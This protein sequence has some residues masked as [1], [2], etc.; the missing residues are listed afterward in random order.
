[1]KGTGFRKRAEAEI[2]RY[3]KDPWVLIR[4]LG[5]N[6]RDAH[7]DRIDVVTLENEDRETLI[8]SDDGRGMT[9][10][11]ARRYLFRLYASSKDDDEFA[12]G[13]YGVG[14]WSVLL[15]KPDTIE[16]HSRT[17]KGCWAVSLSGDL[18][19]WQSISCR[20]SKPGTTVMLVRKRGEEAEEL[21]RAVEAAMIR[22]LSRLRTAGR[23]P[24]PLPVYFNSRRIVRPFKLDSPASLSFSDVDAEGVVGFGRLPSYQLYARGLPV[25]RGSFLEELEGCQVRGRVDRE[26][27][28]VAPVYL[29]NGNHLDVVLSRQMLISNRSLRRLI[30]TARKRFDQL[31]SLTVGCTVKRTV[32]GKIADSL[33]L[34]DLAPL[35]ARWVMF[36]LFVV[37]ITG[38]LSAV[39][40]KIG[41]AEGEALSA[42][43]QTRML[44]QKQA[45]KPGKD[46][47]SAQPD[48]SIEQG[49]A[50]LK[51]QP[52]LRMMPAI[53]P[54]V[55]KE[56]VASTVAEMERMPEWSL[57]YRPGR[58]L[59]F[60]LFVLDK[61]DPARGWQPDGVDNG[62]TA[63]PYRVDRRGMIRVSMDFEGGPGTLLLPVPSGYFVVG[64]NAWIGE[65]ETRLA[66]NR[67]GLL[68]VVL[69][70]EHRATLTYRVAPK[71]EPKSWF[72]NQPVDVELPAHVEARL[73]RIA[74]LKNRN[75]QSREAVDL[76]QSLIHYDRSARTIDAYAAYHDD[77]STPWVQKILAIGTG[78]CDVM[79]GLLVVFLRRMGLPARMVVGIVGQNGRGLSGWHAWVESADT[80]LRVM[81]ATIGSRLLEAAEPIGEKRLVAPAAQVPTIPKPVA[82]RPTAA[83]VLVPELFTR[84][85]M[86]GLLAL[87][88]AGCVWLLMYK[89]RRA[90][91][92]GHISIARNVKKRRKLLASMAT[93]ALQRPAAWRQ[94][95]GL[96]HRSFIPCHGGRLISLARLAQLASR[97]KIFI[98]RRDNFL[99]GEAMGMGIWVLNRDDEDFAEF[100][101]QVSNLRDLD[102]L[103]RLNPHLSENGA[104]RRLIKDMDRFVGRLRLGVACRVVTPVE[105]GLFWDVDLQPIRLSATNGWSK[106]FL[107]INPR[108]PWWQNLAVLYQEDPN[109]AL[110]VAVDHLSQASSLLK[111][112]AALLRRM[113][114]MQA[115]GGRV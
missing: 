50:P 55:T 52:A 89:A 106:R 8:F 31:V 58:D 42:A 84:I 38:S 114:A 92:S 85:L 30:D 60:R 104:A 5:Q 105:D 98:G 69:D 81:D 109:L 48:T 10:E 39:A 95:P 44:A 73:Q 86:W 17:K 21:P 90:G 101:S 76:V 16:V 66:V 115:I 13:R 24:K 68:K 94:V 96:W 12:A 15:F 113:A 25:T 47:S 67:T 108:H 6:S 46:S 51:P 61:F 88:A 23:N 102:E 78:D 97:D 93:D 29:L 87:A 45:E 111:P 37:F 9:F 53:D 91:R 83:P 33:R 22:Y 59:M 57:S 70:R 99:T 2:L 112:R 35:W 75:L 79:N 11:H 100:F 7:A 72:S 56:V 54:V 28:G 65:K 43:Y 4:E 32:F 19:R 26:R 41:R 77:T 49:R 62:W 40:W 34:T 82:T 18:Q 80:D 74:G 20:Q 3:G 36:L 27:Q 14:F 64:P 71:R 110:C 1:M 107:G 63:N 103:E